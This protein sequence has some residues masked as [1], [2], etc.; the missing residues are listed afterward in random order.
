MPPVLSTLWGSEARVPPP[1]VK[2]LL[3]RGVSEPDMRQLCLQR[4]APFLTS[5]HRFCIIL[6]KVKTCDPRF[7]PPAFHQEHRLRLNWTLA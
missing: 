7:V 5:M 1:N 2:K 4:F 3:A 6:F